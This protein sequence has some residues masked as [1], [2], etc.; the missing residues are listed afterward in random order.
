MVSE[1]YLQDR[2]GPPLAARRFF[3]QQVIPAAIDAAAA[4][5]ALAERLAVQVRRAPAPVLGAVLAAGFLAG[6]AGWRRA[7]RR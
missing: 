2:P 5:E 4:V 3:D 7:L 6:W 1:A